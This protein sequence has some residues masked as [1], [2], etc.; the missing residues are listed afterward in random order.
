ML[1]LCPSN[2]VK[3]GKADWIAPFTFFKFAN[4]I[5]ATIMP[6]R[7]LTW[8]VVGTMKNYAQQSPTVT[9]DVFV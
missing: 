9:W 1:F 4:S 2:S 7:A 5:N 3:E 8:L 6:F